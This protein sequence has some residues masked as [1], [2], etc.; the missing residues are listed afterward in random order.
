MLQN[1]IYAKRSAKDFVI[2]RQMELC[3]GFRFE[4][5]LSLTFYESDSLLE[6]GHLSGILYL[7]NLVAELSEDTLKSIESPTT[8]VLTQNVFHQEFARGVFRNVILLHEPLV[9]SAKLPVDTV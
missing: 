8:D 7:R 9:Y 1:T 2:E 4:E 5:M 6:M 3:R